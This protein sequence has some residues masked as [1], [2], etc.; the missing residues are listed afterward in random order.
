MIHTPT[1]KAAKFWPGNLAW[2]ANTALLYARCIANGKDYGVQSFVVP[3]RDMETHATLPGCTIG[4]IGTKLGYNSID[5]GYLMFDKFRVPRSAM[6]A[7]FT[8]IDRQGKFKVVG[9]P[10]MIYQIMV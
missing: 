10:R 3:I 8:Q 1:F 2:Q 7:R 9:N 6:L 5:N 4:D